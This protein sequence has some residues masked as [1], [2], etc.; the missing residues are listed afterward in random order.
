MGDDNISRT[1]Y[2]ILTADHEEIGTLLIEG[3]DKVGVIWA[4]SYFDFA[5]G[6]ATR[7]DANDIMLEIQNKFV[8]ESRAKS[9][10]MILD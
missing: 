5:Q 6:G 2:E 8:P 10:G 4:N 3:K 7:D 1:R 9:P